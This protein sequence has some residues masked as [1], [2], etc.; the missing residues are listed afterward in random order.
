MIGGASAVTQDI[1]PFILADGNKAIPVGL[2][3]IG[4][5]RRGFT[6]RRTFRF[7]ESL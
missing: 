7:K 1:C 5:R 2:N 3:N 6:D 4:L